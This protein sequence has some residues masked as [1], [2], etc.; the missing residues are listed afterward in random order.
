MM[1]VGHKRWLQ[2]CSGTRASRLEGV[3]DLTGGTFSRH[4]M[5][6]GLAAISSAVLR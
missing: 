3:P 2:I 4:I 1:K 5:P 6:M